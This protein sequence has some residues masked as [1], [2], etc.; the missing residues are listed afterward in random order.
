M[1][2][3]KILNTYI[4]ANLVS[5]RIRLFKPY[6][7]PDTIYSKKKNSLYLYVDKADKVNKSG[8]SEIIKKLANF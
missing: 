8:V 3:L 5:N 6:Y 4:K 1:I 7:Y 2:I